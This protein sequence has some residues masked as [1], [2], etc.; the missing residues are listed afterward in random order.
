MPINWKEYRTLFHFPLPLALIGIV[1]IGAVF[2]PSIHLNRLIITYLLV[3]F[4]LVLG[5]YAFDA[6]YADWR[7]VIQNISQTTLWIIAIVGVSGF[8]SIAT[9][10]I[11]KTSLTGIIVAIVLMFFIITY[12]LEFPKWIHNKW[13]FSV[14]WG[15]TPIIASYY[16]QSLTINWIMILLGITGFIF[17]YEEWHTTN[18]KSPIQKR[19]SDLK[20]SV[21]WM[22]NIQ[23][24]TIV[25]MLELDRKFIRKETFKITSIY[26][27][28]LFTLGMTLL[29]WRLT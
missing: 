25:E 22:H 13:G 5:A 29:I 14:A 8:A 7:P 3:I 12:N 2:S 27:Y 21:K 23:Y 11:I 6:M 10:A 18:T 20:I 19:I 26:C 15:A 4:G 28:S 24:D 9:Y 17:A 16:Y 1:T